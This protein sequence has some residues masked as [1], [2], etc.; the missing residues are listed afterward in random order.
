MT[1]VKIYGAGSIGNHLANAAVNKGWEVVLCDIDDMA[2]E[3]TRTSIYPSRYGHFDEKIKLYNIKDAPKTGFDWI[4][5]GTPPNSHL[6]IAIEA[7]DYNPKG[8]LIEKPMATPDLKGCEELL[9]KIKKS[10][11]KVF[12]GYDHVVAKSTKYF[13][14]K[15]K[16]LNNFQYLDVFFREHWDGI[17]KAHYWINGPED[18][19]LGYWKEGGGALAEHSHGLNLWQHIALEIGCGKVIKV[20]ATLDY[21]KT[22]KVN[23]DKL[24]MLHLETEKGLKGSVVQDVLTM[25]TLKSIRLQGDNRSLEWECLTNP[26]SDKVSIIGKEID[27]KVFEKTRPDDFIYELDHLEENLTSYKKSIISVE[28]G[29]DTMLVIAAAHKSFKTGKAITIDYTLGYNEKALK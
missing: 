26:Y 11:T 10:N 12:V 24:A 21:V 27:E 6:K 2:L 1:K 18:T 17:F 28:H 13:V 19:Y 7:L 20:K 14:D 15:A 16:S 5:I 4:F 8:I 3:R 9:D 22:D 23:Y 29:L 25:P